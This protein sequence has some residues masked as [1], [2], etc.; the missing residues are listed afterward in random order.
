MAHLSSSDVRA[1]LK[2]GQTSILPDGAFGPLGVY[3]C[4][5]QPFC[6]QYYY[7]VSA[8]LGRVCGF[9][10]NRSVIAERPEP[11][12][13]PPSGRD[14]VGIVRTI[15]RFLETD[16]LR[17]EPYLAVGIIACIRRMLTARGELGDFRHVPDHLF[18]CILRI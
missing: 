7:M 6:R 8:K 1:G 18:D 2:I 16:T 15:L 5:V 17:V 12:Q 13:Q 10:S 11:R 14:P 4:G 3:H 9:G